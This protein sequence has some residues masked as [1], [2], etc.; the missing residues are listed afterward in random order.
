MNQ[1]VPTKIKSFNELTV[2]K[3]MKTYS[4]R[5][6]SKVRTLRQKNKQNRNK[7]KEEISETQKKNNNDC[8]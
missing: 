8:K 4:I 3:Y 5:N 7:F 1:E 2:V 6:Q